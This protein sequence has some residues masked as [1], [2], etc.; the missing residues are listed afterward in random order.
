MNSSAGGSDLLL[1]PKLTMEMKDSA[2]GGEVEAF[3]E[4]PTPGT[5]NSDRKTGTSLRDD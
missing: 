4:T 5:P 1:L 3:F 2:A